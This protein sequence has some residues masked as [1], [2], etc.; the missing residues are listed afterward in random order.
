MSA[1]LIQFLCIL[2]AVASGWLIGYF[3][4]PKWRHAK[5]NDDNASSYYKGLNYLLSEQAGA[6]VMTGD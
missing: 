2:A 4:R 3:Y 1:E 5:K 6:A